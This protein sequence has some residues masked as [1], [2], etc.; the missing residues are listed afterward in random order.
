MVPVEGVKGNICIR[1]MVDL[2]LHAR[3]RLF[4]HDDP[5]AHARADAG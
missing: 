1:D 4:L 5:F 2:P 3:F